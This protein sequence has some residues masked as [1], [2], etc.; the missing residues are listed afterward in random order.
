MAG[1][2]EGRVIVLTGAEGDIG[3][4]TVRRL[5]AE[6]ARLVLTDL[7]EQ[8]AEE[9][10][11]LELE[12]L[13]ASDGDAADLVDVA[14]KANF[15]SLGARYA[16]QTPA[17]AAMQRGSSAPSASFPS[18]LIDIRSSSASRSTCLR[19][20]KGKQWRCLPQAIAPELHV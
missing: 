7:R 2:L 12:G 13:G 3:R 17:I 11:V 16:K 15:R 9:L 8:V 6:G 1:E 10:N 18:P 19:V 4:A 5:A 20:D 14:V